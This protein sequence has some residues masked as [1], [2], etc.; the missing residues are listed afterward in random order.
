MPVTRL[1][2]QDG[3]GAYLDHAS[4]FLACGAGDTVETGDS[5]TYTE[6]VTIYALAGLSWVVSPGCTPTVTWYGSVNTVTVNDGATGL[7]ISG[8]TLDNTG[9]NSCLRLLGE[10]TG[11]VVDGCVFTGSRA[12][13]ISGEYYAP[14]QDVTLV[15]S[16]ITCK[17]AL[18]S[19]TFAALSVSRCTIAVTLAVLRANSW[20]GTIDRCEIIL[21]EQAYLSSALAYSGTYSGPVLWSNCLV[22]DE[23]TA[24][25]APPMLSIY[26]TTTPYSVLGCTFVGVGAYDAQANIPCIWMDVRAANL[27]QIDIRGN[28]I[29][30]FATGLRGNAG[31]YTDAYNDIWGNGTDYA[32]GTAAGANSISADPLFVGG[33]DYRLQSASPCIG[34]SADL[35]LTE[36]LDGNARPDGML[37]YWIG[38][39]NASGLVAPNVT[40]ATPSSSRMLTVAFDSAMAGADLLDETKYTV[41]DVIGGGSVSV[42]AVALGPGATSVVLTVDAFA[43]S[44]LYRVTV[45]ATITSTGGAMIATRIADFVTSV[46]T[47]P[48]SANPWAAGP[49]GEAVDL[50]TG[51][52]ELINWEGTAS[53]SLEQLVWISLFTDRAA[54]D[55]DTLPDD[56]GDPIYRGGWWGDTYAEIPGRKIGSRLWLLRN[57]P[58]TATTPDVARAYID[59]ALAWMVQDGIVARVESRAERIG[60]DKLGVGVT[61]YDRA[62]VLAAN[63]WYDDLWE[64]YRNG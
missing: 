17:Q 4:A 16:T 5:G 60:T 44:T 25:G 23:N 57:R 10:C 26:D 46:W 24:W 3:S 40:G 32:A 38:A 37:R 47:E 42:T 43:S 13:A 30:G 36:D 59:E 56:G 58:L 39:Y 1:V 62:G 14:G 48:D 51:A 15:D 6:R 35:G 64:V 2:R 22:V 50:G 52:Y 8:V 45:P 63:L 18:F 54:E 7:T 34:A 9:P 49:D 53:T 31:T 61:L 11:L 27:G 20:Q 28:I 29:T 19:P 55:G 12:T 41:T 33:G 21:S